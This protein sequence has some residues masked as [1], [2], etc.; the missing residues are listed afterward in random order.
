MSSAPDEPDASGRP[1]GWRPRPTWPSGGG[2]VDWTRVDPRRIGRRRVD[3]SRVDPRRIDWTRVDPRRIDRSRVDPRRVDGSR[4]AAAPVAPPADAPGPSGDGRAVTRVVRGWHET[5]TL[6]IARLPIRVRL[7]GGSAALTLV[8]LCIFAVA[9]GS[10]TARRIRADFTS[11]LT[12]AADNIA[13]NLNIQYDQVLRPIITPDLN[14]AAAPDHAVVRIIGPDLSVV[15]ETLDAPDLGQLS[16]APV[17]VGGYRVVTVSAKASNGSVP[18]FVQYGRPV[19]DLDKTIG[20]LQVFLI[21]GVLG[22]TGLAFGAGTMIARRAMAPIAALTAAAGEVERTRDP[23]RGVPASESED[24]VAELG[25]TLEGMLG[26]LAGA[27]AET[28]A[29]LDRQRAFVA[30]ASHELRTPLTS[31]LANLE[32]LSETLHG[33]EATAAQSALRSS[34]RMR[35]LVEDLLLLARA[36]VSRERVN[37]PFDLAEVVVEA[38]GEL[39]PMSGGHVVEL[40]ARPAPLTGARDDVQRLATNL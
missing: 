39:G 14:V 34:Q 29:M 32:L 9:I 37:R 20:R 16:G 11:Q 27:R 7:A 4:L 17:D 35:R 38:A 5:V 6:P 22:G 25:R 40:D 8:I 19:S 36:D 21:F 1:K 31:V 3:W 18:V 2:R 13:A 26:A 24:E 10:L 15:G 23:S 12:S 33:E 28:E 30:D